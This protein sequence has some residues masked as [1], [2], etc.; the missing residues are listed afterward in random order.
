M[1]RYLPWCINFH[2][3]RMNK[4]KDITLFLCQVIY[5]LLV[6][7]VRRIDNIKIAYPELLRVS[8]IVKEELQRLGLRFNHGERH[9]V[10]NTTH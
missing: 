6:K 9:H 1:E 8:V 10:D 5:L 4:Y 2:M 7:A 3:Q